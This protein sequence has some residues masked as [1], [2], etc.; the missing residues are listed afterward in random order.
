MQVFTDTWLNHSTCCSRCSKTR[1]NESPRRLSFSFSLDALCVTAL[2]ACTKHRVSRFDWTDG[3]GSG[4]TCVVFFLWNAET[5][6]TTHTGTVSWVELGDAGHLPMTIIATCAEP[7]EQ[8]GSTHSSR[9]TSSCASGRVKELTLSLLNRS[10]NT[11]WS[12]MCWILAL[13]LDASC[14]SD[15]W[16]LIL[17]VP[18]SLM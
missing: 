15:C 17:L 14:E 7:K 3:Q 12:T 11:L 2:L 1:C 8:R 9:A 10:L 16:R 13:R 6:T 4:R 18:D 5:N